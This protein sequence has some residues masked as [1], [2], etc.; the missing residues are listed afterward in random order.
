MKITKKTYYRLDNFDGYWIRRAVAEVAGLSSC[1]GE[2]IEFSTREIAQ[3]FAKL[4]LHK[5]A[6]LTPNVNDRSFLST[7]DRDQAYKEIGSVPPASF[8]E[9]RFV[10]EP[11][12]RIGEW[13]QSILHRNVETRIGR[14]VETVKTVVVDGEEFTRK[15]TE[16]KWSEWYPAHA[17]K[18][19]ISIYENTRVEVA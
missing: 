7:R 6:E 9:S 5:Y 16:K 1:D 10:G 13:G 18:T 15:T 11:E 3:E 19:S 12:I 2:N 4:I 8:S 17:E 14:D